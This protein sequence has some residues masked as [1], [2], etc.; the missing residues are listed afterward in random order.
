MN[1]TL[2]WRGCWRIAWRDLH[3]GLRGLRLL[4][5][6]LFLGVAALATI[7][8]LTAA[9]TGEI[10]SKGQSL[11]GGDLEIAMAQRE[12]SASEK[13]AFRR[14]G[15][16]SETIRLRAMAQRP[17]SGDGPS[18]VLTELKGVDRAYPLYGTLMLKGGPAGALKPDEL[19][20]GQALADRL[21]LRRGQTLRYGEAL[22]RIRDII[23]HEPDRV[24][25]G[26]TLGP[27]AITSLEGV[28]RTALIQPGSL[29]ESKYRIRLPA[30][31]NA[32]ASGEALK[33]A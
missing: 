24:G 12:A 4:F 29:Y 6:C 3:R 18:A 11:L 25:E 20:I 23:A 9:I 8:S 31:A 26:F 5:V 1:P 21:A 28:R 30:G 32:Q 2:G 33:R 17:G 19:V 16:L 14:L 10:A 22:F 15:Q 27:V 13:S 7:G